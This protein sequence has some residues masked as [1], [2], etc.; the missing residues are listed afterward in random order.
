MA[1]P[2]T[3]SQ[4]MVA[5]FSMEIGIRPD[6]PTYSG[7]LG[8]LAGDTLKSAADLGVPMLGITLVHR[9][10]YFRQR[11]DAAG[12]QTELPEDWQPEELLE[13]VPATITIEL[14]GRLVHLRAWRYRLQG[15]AGHEVPIYFLDT[16][17]P[18]NSEWDRALTD[19]LYGG[20]NYYRLCQEVVLGLGGVALL[21]ALGL[22]EHVIYHMNEG[23]SSL[24][25]LALLERQCPNGEPTEE[26]IEAVR[27]HCVFTTHTPVP[28]GHDKFTWD[29]ARQVLGERRTRLLEISQCCING[30]LNMTYLALRFAR[31]INGVAMRHG[32][33]S[34]S[35]FP[36]YPINAITNGVHAITWTSPPF[37]SLYDQRIPE[38]RADNFY[39]RYAIGIPLTEIA[40]AHREAKRQLL[41]A[42][43]QQTGRS[44]AEEVFTLGFARRA[45]AYK[46]PDLLFSDLDRL[47]RLAREVGPLQVIYGGKAHPRDEGGKEMIRRVF[48]AAAALASDIPVIYVENYD[49]TW[50]K[51]LCAGVD[52]WLNTPQRPQEASGTSGMKAALNGVPSLSVLDG[53]WLEGHVEQVTGWAIGND[54]LHEDPYVEAAS[55]YDKLEQIILPLYYR[56]PEE[57]TRIQRAAIAINGSFFNTQRMV[58]QYVSNAY[59]TVELLE[60]GSS[61]TCG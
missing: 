7:G 40:A 5:Y 11:L 14:A 12:N 26:D 59:R 23:H 15:L 24:L 22:T 34:T 1:G 61:P 8:I 60:S 55:L 53:W 47:R 31:Y 58:A 37:A 9:R 16:A 21:E 32:E 36:G 57:Y 19:Y 35:M 13:P 2:K 54:S 50:G 44:L 4:V 27:Q 25:A 17:L 39:L 43:A 18:E 29:L 49:M 10:G 41:A 56:Q 20:D 52:L 51:L 28:A 38:W 42:I 3:L 46:R 30:Y 6:M 45:T 48:A 33:I